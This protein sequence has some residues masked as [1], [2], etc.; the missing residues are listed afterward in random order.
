MARGLVRPHG[1]EREFT[2]TTAPAVLD[3]REPRG[4]IIHT[5]SIHRPPTPFRA[6]VWSDHT[7]LGACAEPPEGR[8]VESIPLPAE[9]IPGCPA[10]P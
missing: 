1:D 3:E 5:G 7:S 10:S 8:I 4:I 9:S 6:F 2:V